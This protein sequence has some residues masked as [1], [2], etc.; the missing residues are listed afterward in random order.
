MHQECLGPSLGARDARKILAGR[1]RRPQHEGPWKHSTLIWKRKCTPVGVPCSNLKTILR[2]ALR[3]AS[4]ERATCFTSIA[5]DRRI[6][7][8]QRHA[9]PRPEL[10]TT[11]RNGAELFKTEIERARIVQAPKTPPDVKRPLTDLGSPNTEAPA[12]E[13]RASYQGRKMLPLTTY[14]TAR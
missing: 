2:N 10:A 13:A 7:P 4:G 8:D 9:A 1:P 14:G 6:D 11:N 5:P 3:C 12:L